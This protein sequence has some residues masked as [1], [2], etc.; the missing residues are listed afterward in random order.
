MPKNQITKK[1]VTVVNVKRK[2][3]SSEEESSEAE[4][5]EGEKENE[6]LI[7]SIRTKKILKDVE[8]VFYEDQEKIK[9]QKGPFVTALF[10]KVNIRCLIDTAAQASAMS[11]ETYEQLKQ[12]G[13]RMEKQPVEKMQLMGAFS[14][15]TIKILFNTII[16]FTIDKTRFEQEIL[17]VD[18]LIH[19]I[20]FGMDFICDHNAAIQCPHSSPE[21]GIEIELESK[22]K[23]IVIVNAIMIEQE[24]P[25]ITNC[26]AEEMGSFFGILNITEEEL[27]EG[28]E[29]LFTQREIVEVFLSDESEGENR[30]VKNRE[31]EERRERTNTMAIE[32]IAEEEKNKNVAVLNLYGPFFGAKLDQKY[33]LMIIDARSG[34]KKTYYMPDKRLK[35]LMDTITNKYLRTERKP[36]AIVTDRQGQFRNAK[37]RIFCNKLGIEARIPNPTMNPARG[38]TDRGNSKIDLQEEEEN[39]IAENRGIRE[40]KKQLE[41]LQKKLSREMEGTPSPAKSR[42]EPRAKEMQRN[43]REVNDGD[44][45]ME[46]HP[47]RGSDI[48]SPA[49][50]PENR[51]KQHK[52]SISNKTREEEDDE[53]SICILKQ[54]TQSGKMRKVTENPTKTIENL[55]QKKNRRGS[56]QREQ[57]NENSLTNIQHR[58]ETES[59]KD[60]KRPI[61]CVTQDEN[62]NTPVNKKGINQEAFE[63]MLR[64]KDILSE[65]IPAKKML[66]RIQKSKCKVYMDKE[67]Q[68]DV[69]TTTCR[70][71][72]EKE[73]GEIEIIHRE[74]L[75]PD[76]IKAISD[77]KVR[78]TRMRAKIDDKEIEIHPIILFGRSGAII[79]GK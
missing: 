65:R 44:S 66:A 57:M 1:H 53:E 2:G 26:T 67:G 41:T 59:A 49:R 74:D 46:V 3:S 56:D 11:M 22:D 70:E 10:N 21:E 7:A 5:H 4:S 64:A 61:E 39:I 20:V 48:D 9:T 69:I 8:E 29:P 79:L 78:I 19:D 60:L 55:K 42:L 18:K 33:A 24:A 35:T 45:E 52:E 71:R 43:T 30:D 12:D 25:D 63:L 32:K 40:M 23:N 72:L 77:M 13:I 68:C 75:I 51:E 34:S 14:K 16:N 37:W 50:R 6:S 47:K 58:R 27:D 73:N 17:V 38:S 36:N 62:G 54:S 76:C 31:T 15:K 28:D